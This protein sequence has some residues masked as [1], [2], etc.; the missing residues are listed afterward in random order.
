MQA[1]SLRLTKVLSRIYPASAAP[2]D[3]IRINHSP[4]SAGSGKIVAASPN[5]CEFLQIRLHSVRGGAE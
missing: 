5:V 2:R 1:P 4:S 3:L